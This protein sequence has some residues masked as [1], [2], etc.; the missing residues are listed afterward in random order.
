MGRETMLALVRH[1]HNKS[2]LLTSCDT[3]MAMVALVVSMVGRKVAFATLS[4]TYEGGGG[5]RDWLRAEPG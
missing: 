4:A 1:L 5:E 3:R 2:V